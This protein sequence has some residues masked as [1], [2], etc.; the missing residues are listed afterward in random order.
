MDD[1]LKEIRF[2]TKKAAKFFTKKMAYTLGPAELKEL[3]EQGCEHSKIVIIDVRAKE[4]YDES[5]IPGAI[6]IPRKDLDAHLEH[7]SKDDLHIVYCYNQQCHLATCACRLLALNDYPCME[8]EGG[9]N[10][11]VDD[12]RYAT[13]SEK[14]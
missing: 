13:V 11:W 12:F 6:S 7:L 10:V 1:K 8:L 3:M 2:D 4:D 9:F 14:E 5:H